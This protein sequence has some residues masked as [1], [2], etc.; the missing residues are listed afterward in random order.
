M[1]LVN[2]PKSIVK[3]VAIYFLL[4][5]SFPISLN[6]SLLHDSTL[7]LVFKRDHDDESAKDYYVKSEIH[8]K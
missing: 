5:S 8:F 7:E 1:T 3:I 6:N 2:L 4:Q